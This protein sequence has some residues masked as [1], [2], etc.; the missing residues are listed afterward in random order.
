MS[1]LSLYLPPTIETARHLRNAMYPNDGAYAGQ[2][3]ALNHCLAYRKKGVYSFEAVLGDTSPAPDNWRFRFR[4]GHGTSGVTF[5][6]IIGLAIETHSEPAV[7]IALTEEG[8][9]TTS[10]VLHYGATET[11]GTGA[12]EEWS[13]Q[14]GTIG[15]NADS[16]YT[17]L[18]TISGGASNISVSA[19][20]TG[21][22]TV[23]DSVDFFSEFQPGAGAGIYDTHI[24]KLIEGPS[25]MLRQNRSIC[26]HWHL[27]DGAARTGTSA[28]PTSLIDNTLTGTPSSTAAGWRF[29]TTAHNTYG[30]TTIPV[31]LSI[32]GSITGGAT[33]TVRIRDTSGTD[34]TVNITAGSDQWTTGTGVI[35]VGTGQLYVPMYAS[36]G[37][38][39]ISI[40]AVSLWAWEA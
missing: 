10:I 8:G 18:I 38:A 28:T 36:D 33:G 13:I 3:E 12:P 27:I 25:E 15:V 7:T 4:T 5:V 6:A 32:Y 39:T 21:R 23:T 35:S 9:A 31:E 14:E 22:T 40:K 29:V 20:E 2:I 24:Q 16:A 26:A 11:A 1:L 30:R 37:A 19:F 17:C 34:L